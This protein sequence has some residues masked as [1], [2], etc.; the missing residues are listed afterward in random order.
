MLITKTLEPPSAV[1]SAFELPPVPATSGKGADAAARRTAGV[2]LL[3][4]DRVTACEPG[5]SGL[6]P[7][8]DWTLPEPIVAASLLPRGR[9]LAFGWSGACAVVQLPPAPAEAPGLEAAAL[10]SA[11]APAL[12]PALVLE[13]LPPQSAPAR[14]AAPG[15]AEREAPQLGRAAVS[16]PLTLAGGSGSGGWQQTHVLAAR[17]HGTLQ[18]VT[19]AAAPE[20]S[21]FSGGGG[22]SASGEGVLSATTFNA[23]PALLTGGLPGKCHIGSGAGRLQFKGSLPQGPTAEQKPRQPSAP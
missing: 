5:P 22:G 21:R 18:L 20:G 3:R 10:T 9:L 13:S 19:W 1:L 15:T 23:A 16:A 14:Y 11:A 17:S 4:V 8:C 2:L 12:A 7:V 6:D